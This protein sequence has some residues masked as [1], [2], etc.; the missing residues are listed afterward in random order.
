MTETEMGYSTSCKIKRLT[1]NE[2][3]FEFIFRS[4]KRE[5][6]LIKL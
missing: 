3:W 1:N 2:M 5:I 4:S 6:H